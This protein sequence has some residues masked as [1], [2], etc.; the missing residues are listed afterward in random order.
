M[1]RPTRGAHTAVVSVVGAGET[2]A[3][4][5]YRGGER[6]RCWGDRRV[7]HTRDLARLSEGLSFEQ[8]GDGRPRG[9]RDARSRPRWLVRRPRPGGGHRAVPRSRDGHTTPGSRLARLPHVLL[10]TGRPLEGAP[11]QRQHDRDRAP[12]VAA[13]R[14]Q[15]RHPPRGRPAR[16]FDRSVCAARRSRHDQYRPAGVCAPRVGATRPVGGSGRSVCATRRCKRRLED[17]ARLDQNR[18][19]VRSECVHQA[20][21][22]TA[23]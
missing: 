11:D 10:I 22:P 12:D 4:R 13:V 7:A 19:Q 2:D 21:V 14:E 6:G 5:T 9:E 18:E 17:H 15:G 1:R 23:A 8:S 16:G 3:W 20:P